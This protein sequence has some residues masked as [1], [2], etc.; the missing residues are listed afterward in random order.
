MTETLERVKTYQQFIGGDF[1]DAADGR[2][3][4]V[5]NPAND[6]VI[7]NVPASSQEDV[8]RAVERRRRPPSRRWKKTTPQDR[9]LLPAQD[10]RRARGEGRRARPARERQ[11][12]Q[13]GRRGDRRDG[14]LRR[15]VP[16]LRRCRAGHGRPRR[17]R[18]RWPA[19]PRSSGATRSAS[20]RRSRRGTTR[21]TWRRWKLGPALATGNTVVLK[22]SARTPL[23]RAG[24][25]RDPRRDPA[26]GRRQRAVRLGRRHRR[27]AG[28]PSEG[29]DG[30][31]HRRHGD[32]QAGRQD[33]RRHRQAPAPRARRQGADHRVRRRRHRARGRDAALRRLL[34]LPARTAP[35][36]R[37]SSPA[38]RSTTTSCRP[39]PTRSGRSSGATRPRATTSRWARSSPRPR[40]TRSRAW[41]I[42]PAAAPRSSSAASGPTGRAPTTSRPSSPARTRS[43]RSSRTRSSARS[44][45]SS[46]SATRRQAVAVGERHA[47]RPRVVDLHERH[48]Q[49]DARRQGARVRPRLDQR[50]LHARRRRRRTAA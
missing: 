43:R 5:I 47:L 8:D 10:R 11:R 35:R 18:V 45:R 12:R 39:W 26:A 17:Q 29:P 32:R 42:A 24:V 2:T 3:A 48:R 21:S 20:S 31:D 41:S 1:V 15:P 30:L 28:R 34:E 46:A 36:R 16:L 13:A 4:E 22:P 7:A 27:R 38:R 40:P 25:R 9:S 23:T 44:S 6:Q 37:A 14:R 50:A 49:G 19:T 33:R